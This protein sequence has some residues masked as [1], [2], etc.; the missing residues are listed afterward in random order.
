MA[1]RT[2]ETWFIQSRIST[3]LPGDPRNQS[4]LIIAGLQMSVR[5]QKTFSHITCNS[6]MILQHY[7]LHCKSVIHAMNH[8]DSTEHFGR[9]SYNKNTR[10]EFQ[11]C[12]TTSGYLEIGDTLMARGSLGLGC[13][14]RWNPHTLDRKDR[15]PPLDLVGE[16]CYVSGNSLKLQSIRQNISGSTLIIDQHMGEVGWGLLEFAHMCLGQKRSKQDL[17]AF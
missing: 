12:T 9:K 2:S 16:T 17:E 1:R 5:M 13:T 14:K 3:S 4:W 15:V 8:D 7:V 10:F 6:A 11:H